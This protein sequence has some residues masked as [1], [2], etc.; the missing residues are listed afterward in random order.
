MFSYTRRDESW[1]HGGVGARQ[2]KAVRNAFA[3]LATSA[4]VPM[5]MGGDELFRTQAGCDN[6]AALDNPD[7]YLRW[8]DYVQYARA[9]QAGDAASLARLRQQD[10]IRIY[11]FARKMLAFRSRH[12]CLRPDRYFTGTDRWGTGLRDLAWY[13][14][15][16]QEFRGDW[17]DSHICFLGFRIDSSPDQ[18][19]TGVRSIYAA[20]N[21][22]DAGVNIALPPNLAGARWVRVADTAEWMEPMGNVDREEVVIERNYGLH[23]RSIA[24]FVEK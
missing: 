12:G 19:A 11:E 13:G 7:M 6:A 8:D 17:A 23:E 16:G 22:N 20:Y 21:W 24:L 9:G 18:Q 2:R 4:G 1:D 10:D 3:L 5:F 15:D 14:A